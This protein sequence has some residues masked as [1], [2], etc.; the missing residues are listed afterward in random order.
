MSHSLPLA[1]PRLWLRPLHSTRAPGNMVTADPR[2][3]TVY[4]KKDSGFTNF[5]WK[6]RETGA[7]DEV[8]D[9]QAAHFFFL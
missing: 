7:E 5:C 6:D 3:G 8:S 2:R 4:L 1:H 9:T